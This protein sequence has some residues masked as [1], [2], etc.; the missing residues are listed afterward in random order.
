MFNN[1]PIK[2]DCGAIVAIAL[3]TVADDPL[4]FSFECLM[5]SATHLSEEYTA[6]LLNPVWNSNAVWLTPLVA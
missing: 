2:N 1:L 3:F 4:P 6:K 5:E